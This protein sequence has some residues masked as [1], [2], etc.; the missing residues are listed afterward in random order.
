[1][2]EKRTTF[3]RFTSRPFLLTVIAALSSIIG[4]YN[5][6]PAEKIAMIVAAVAPFVLGES[7]RDAT[8]AKAQA[9]QTPDTVNA[10][11]DVTLQTTRDDEP[12][13]LEIL[14]DD[15][16]ENIQAE[17]IAEQE[18]QIANRETSDSRE[19]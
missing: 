12:A 8:I 13:E 10:G 15:E 7:Y 14:P 4:A 6:I 19:G 3:E 5:D 1:M 16:A 9:P 17:A 2:N 18:A 11:G